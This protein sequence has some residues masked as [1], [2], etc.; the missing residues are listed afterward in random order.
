MRRKKMITY[1]CVLT[2]LCGCQSGENLPEENPGKAGPMTSPFII[3]S[4]AEA[5]IEASST[6]GTPVAVTS[7]SIGVF[8]AD[9]A[10]GNYE[11]RNNA[12][13]TYDTGKAAWT[14]DDALFFNDG[15]ANVC[16]YYP[17]DDTQ[18]DSKKIV[19]TTQVYDAAKD[20]SF[21]TDQTMN[22]TNNTVSF[23]M[24][25][26]YALLELHLKRDAVKDDLTFKQIDLI[27]PGMT[28]TGNVDITNGTFDTPVP[29]TDGKFSLTE[30][31]TLSKNTST[32]V[33]KVLIVPTNTLAGGTKF[34][35]TLDDDDSTTMS[36][37]ISSLT[38]YEKKKRY[39]AN[40]T[41][42]GTDVVVNSVNVVAW[43]EVSLGS[44]DSP[45]TPEI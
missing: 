41:I 38:Q 17:Y 45:Y 19:L 30:T 13:Y 25:H 8:L 31:F 27:A 9:A 10:S 43:T 18:T 42:N 33:H 5:A 12:R 3:E 23:N 15:D 20:L 39:I 21:A 24:N 4:V 6:R 16:A 37:T 2:L 22:A 26:A 34:T 11:P 35:F 1:A 29:A 44:E 32:T 40:L 14:S 36:V 7:G 28:N